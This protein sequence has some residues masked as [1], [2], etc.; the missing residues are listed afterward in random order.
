MRWMWMAAVAAAGLSTVATAWAGPPPGYCPADDGSPVASVTVSPRVSVA[1]PFLWYEVRNLGS[2]CIFGG[3]AARL[4]RQQDGTWIPAQTGPVDSPRFILRPGSSAQLSIAP[5]VDWSLGR[6]RII[7]AFS[8]M[9]SA[10]FEVVPDGCAGADG[11]VA[12]TVDGV[13]SQAGRAVTGRAEVRFTAWVNPNCADQH[14]HVEYAR[15]AGNE[16][17]VGAWLRTPSSTVPSSG[18]SAIVRARAML[19]PGTWS[20]RVVAVRPE[21]AVIKAAPSFAVHAEPCAVQVRS[22]SARA[23][24]SGRIGVRVIGTGG[25]CR[26]ATLAFSTL[27]ERDGTVIQ[28]IVARSRFRLSFGQQRLVH[29]TLSRRARRLLAHGPLTISTSTQTITIHS[30]QRTG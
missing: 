16:N 28:P 25:P 13:T 29:L 21:G 15:A 12:P 11:A 23:S 20:V 7:A 30:A 9:P 19:G 1:Q 3:E 5:G 6:Y 18:G 8:A 22:A 17:S 27:I 2:T 26:P 14:V 24:R 10:E 4:E